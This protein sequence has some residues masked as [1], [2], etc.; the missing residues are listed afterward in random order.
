[1]TTRSLAAWVEHAAKFRGETPVARRWIDEAIRRIDAGEET[2]AR[3]PNGKPSLKGVF[4]IATRLES[5]SAI[6]N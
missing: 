2:V 3:Y 5:E 4:D 1:M 6:K